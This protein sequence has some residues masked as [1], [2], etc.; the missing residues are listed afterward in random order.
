MKSLVR[1]L[2]LAAVVSLTLAAPVRPWRVVAAP[3]DSLYIAAQRALDEGRP[4]RASRILEPA[5]RDS[6]GRTP[7]RVLLAARAARSWGGAA[8][9]RKLLEREPW[10][11]DRYDAEGRALLAWAALA[12]R[13]DTAAVV[14]AGAAVAGAKSP[15]LRAERAVLLARALD[16]LEQR[17]SAASAYLAAAEGLSPIA[18]WLRLR[19]IVVTGDS[20]RRAAIAA[21]IE[22]PLVRAR[23]PWAEA[24]A[25][26]R[27]GDSA[28]AAA[29]YAALG[30][31]L[32]ALRLRLPLAA[33]EARDPLRR[34]LLAFVEGKPSSEGTRDA[35]TLLERY[36]VEFSAADQLAIARALDRAGDLGRAVRYYQAAVRARVATPADRHALGEL[37]F[38]LGKY[39]DAIAVFT[40]LRSDKKLGG[41]A[42]YQVARAQVR[43]G[44]TATA[45]TLLNAIPKKYAADTEAVARALF[46]LGDLST[47]AQ[48]DAAA[49]GYWRRLAV[50]YPTA[51]LAPSARFRAA[52]AGLVL[53]HADSAAVEF[54]ELVERYGS[55]DEVNSSLYWGGRAWAERGDSAAARER[56]RRVRT[57][58]V[59]S[60]YTV[61]AAAR[62]GEPAWAPAAAADTFVVLPDVEMGMA[63]AALLERLGLAPEAEKEYA[64]LRAEA[65]GGAERLLATAEAFR[66]AGRGADAI[67]LARRILAKSPDADARVYR[68]VY[69]LTYAQVVNTE[70][71]A[72]GFDP[73][74][75]AA[76]IRQESAFD[77]DVTSS[78][79]ARGLMQLLPEVGRATARQLGYPVW[80]AALLFQPDVSVELGTAH[81]AQLRDSYPETVQLLAAYNAG[82]HRV[83]KWR[84]RG[85]VADAEL[86]AERIPFVET[87]DYVRI[88][89][90][91]RQLYKLL[92]AWD[93]MG[94]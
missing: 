2:L 80:D 94:A 52:I 89:Q 41:S 66:V 75:V 59:R 58:D 37:L 61:L 7:D 33:R 91:N 31:P 51:K 48:Q 11:D 49:R 8:D 30:A 77:P 29:R 76:L 45:V 42:A 25:L 6:L 57:R 83:V 14:Q 15:R 78:A 26:E 73:A 16:R 27:R 63:R 5:L 79:G 67:A 92:Y 47:D 39:D 19:A 12:E 90:R 74:L 32:E 1:G 84:T 17:D 62:L 70:A 64:R 69:P 87:R 21:R 86:F 65:D 3:P 46:L 35:V 24:Q 34:Q 68:L 18:D 22:Q 88:I 43:K 93:D 13:R 20:A 38:R 60:Y 81:L 4:W 72:H 54:D 36:T 82:A 40:P 53:G 56:W 85:G 50:K 71:R 23:L 10:L 44:E 28:G 9:V 55:S